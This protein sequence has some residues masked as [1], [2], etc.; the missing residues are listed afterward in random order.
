MLDYAI[1]LREITSNPAKDVPG[2]Q[3]E[4]GAKLPSLPAV[5]AF[6]AWMYGQGEQ[7]QV[8]AAMAECIMLAGS[9]NVELRELEWSSVDFSRDLLRTIRAK[10]RGRQRGA[11]IEEISMSARMRGA[12]THMYGLR[13][14][15]GR[16][17]VYVFPNQDNNAYTPKAFNSMWAR[18]MGDAI[19]ARVVRK[20]DR[21]T[22]HSL[23]S[24]YATL[25][26]QQ[27]GSLPD[28]HKDPGTTARV[29]DRNQ[30]IPRDSL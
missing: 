18:S 19:K 5:E 15:R 21:F 10:Q 23:R 3:I 25:H 4:S 14:A 8:I 20:E 6:L 7:R 24:L 28:L 13:A 30:L 12:L 29:Y 26:K 9:R 17:C 22:F 1:I 2:H 11:I 16:G 27:L